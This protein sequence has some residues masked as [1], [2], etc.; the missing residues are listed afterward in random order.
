MYLGPGVRGDQLPQLPSNYSPV[1]GEQGSKVDLNSLIG[2]ILR[3]KRV[4]FSVL[5]AFI[6]L[7]ILWTLLVPRS[8]TA[9]TMLIA[10]APGSGAGQG[11]NTT[12]LPLLNALLAASGTQSAET[13]VNLIQQEPIAEQV[14]ANLHLGMGPQKLLN[15]L[16][17]TPVTQT[18]IIE[19]DATFPDPRTAAKVA[20]EF[21]SVFVSRERDLVAGQASSALDFLAKQMPVSE[22]AMHKADNAL[23]KFQAEHP[24]IYSN[25]GTTTSAGVDSVST[26]QQKFAQV[27]VDAGQAQAELNN[28]TGQMGSVAQ[29]V[30]GSSNIN[31]NPVVAQL[32]NQLAQVDVQLEA[33]RKQYTDQHPTVIGLEEQKAQIQKEIQSQPATIVSGNQIVVNPVYQ[34]LSGQAANLRAQIASD[35]AQLSILRAQMGGGDD[36]QNLPRQTIQLADLQRNAKLA[37][38][39]YA[40]LQSKFNDATVAKTTALSDVAITQPAT[41]D[42]VTVKPNWKINIILA[43][44]LGLVLAISSVFIVDFFD[45]TFKDEQDVHRALALPLLTTVPQLSAKSQDKLPWLRALTIES[46]LQLVTALRYSSDEPLR[47]LAI[48]SPNEGDGKSTIAISTAIAMAEMEPKV[49]LVDADMRKPT[50]HDR[51]GLSNQIGLSDLLIGATA[52]ET[53]V[54]QTKY[55]GLYFIG[56]GTHV[57]SPVKLLHSTRFNDLISSLLKQYRIIVFDTPALL[58][59]SDA[60]V[61]A[62]KVNG[63]VMVVSAGMTDMI[64]TKKALQRLSAIPGVNVLGIV[65]NRA[66]PSNGYKAY[67]LN[68]DS[69]ASLPHET[70]VV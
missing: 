51:L 67:Y 47:T 65:L 40:A 39:I 57:P 36:T 20:N 23:A 5:I 1:S 15:N 6:S 63:T 64:S 48:T 29:S 33:A 26:A 62:S 7:V 53:V 16:N 22:A 18:A 55:E 31:Q 35:Q 24:N 25:A 38:D 14:A 19:L 50:L 4:F 70:E 28:V 66:T 12:G 27:Q 68:G 30:N 43:V 69:P 8:Y 9:T 10:G 52:L 61:L 34:Q 46:F 17:V 59:V 3:R 49:V 13:Y 58:P 56:S 21:A 41:P 2:T 60:T 44:V 37:E 45:N 42:N 32:Q 11:A 54:Q